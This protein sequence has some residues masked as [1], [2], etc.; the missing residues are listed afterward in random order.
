MVE[1]VIQ[2]VFES[3][4]QVTAQNDSI[5]VG[6]IEFRH[7]F[8]VIIFEDKAVGLQDVEVVDHGLHI[9]EYTSQDACHVMIKAVILVVDPFLNDTA[10]DFIVVI[11]ERNQFATV[12]VYTQMDV[13]YTVLID[14]R[15]TLV[16][17]LFDV[18]SLIFMAPPPLF[19]IVI[20]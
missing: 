9:V 18:C 12:L 20:D 5:V 19:G 16:G 15:G 6:H 2:F 11:I 10:R 4:H 3:R 14:A 7:C 17:N 8:P 1:E 13:G